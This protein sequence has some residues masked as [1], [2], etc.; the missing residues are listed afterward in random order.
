MSGSYAAVTGDRGRL[1]VPEEVRA[2]HGFAE[3]IPVLSMESPSVP[4]LTTREGLPARLQAELE[5]ANLVEELLIERRREAA[6]E[7]AG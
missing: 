7:D 5:G 3:G 6:I 1:V 4:V 2:R